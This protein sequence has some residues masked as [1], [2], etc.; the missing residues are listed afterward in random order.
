MSLK[1][2]AILLLALL[3]AAAGIAAW[4]YH[5]RTAEKRNAD[6]AR[7]IAEHARSVVAAVQKSWNADD[8]WEDVFSSPGSPPTPYTINVE[9]ALIKE[10]P[11]I[12]FGTVDDVRTSGE[13]G[14]SI[15]SVQCKGRTTKFRLGLLHL[16]LSL[17]SAPDTTNSLLRNKP[18]PF[19]TY[20]FAATITSVENVPVAP[21]K[22]DNDQDYFLA[23]GT[24]QE[25][26]PIGTFPVPSK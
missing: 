8:D 13:N 2:K 22:Y 14:N 7:A 3:T 19:E 12:F 9:R 11:L 10:R 16:R 21:D 6:E 5:S 15:V 20:V 4:F 24:L 25:A 23:H 1:L 26:Q 18:R 17:L